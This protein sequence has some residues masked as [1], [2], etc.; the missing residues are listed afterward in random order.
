MVL[1]DKFNSLHTELTQRQ[2]VIEARALLQNV[3]AVVEETNSQIQEIAASGSFDT[4]DTEIKQA[5]IAG[6][7]VVKDA[8]TGFE[9][10]IIA[11]LLDWRP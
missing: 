6:W 11:E 9:D 1:T 4:I 8:K 3:R 5:L 2:K 7:N 10:S